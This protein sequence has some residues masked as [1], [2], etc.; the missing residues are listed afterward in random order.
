MHA[1]NYFL[2]SVPSK[3][4][5]TINYDYQIIFTS[6][7]ISVPA[8]QIRYGKQGQGQSK[9][10]AAKLAALFESILI[11]ENLNTVVAA[12]V[13]NIQPGANDNVIDFTEI[14]KWYKML[15]ERY[16]LTL[17]PNIYPLLMPDDLSQLKLLLPPFITGKLSKTF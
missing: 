5:T 10:E 17:A 12:T 16:N 13:H 6:E 8:I 4:T 1:M 7:N 15:N 14:N 3:L 2:C 9:V 11:E